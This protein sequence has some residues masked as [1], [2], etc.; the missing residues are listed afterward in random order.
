MLIASL[1]VTQNLCSHIPNVCLCGE[2]GIVEP[3]RTGVEDGVRLGLGKQEQDDF[4]TASENVQRKRLE[5]E[6]QAMEDE[7]RRERREVGARSAMALWSK[8]DPG[9]HSVR[10]CSEGGELAGQ[11]PLVLRRPRRM[12]ALP[13]VHVI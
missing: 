10:G 2:T 13:C 5:T 11:L 3:V 4:Y 6:I 9:L 1:L 12:I 7:A 8:R